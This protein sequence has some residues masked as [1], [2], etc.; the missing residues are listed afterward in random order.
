MI[1]KA[2][3]GTAIDLKAQNFMKSKNE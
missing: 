2:M 1:E 3:I